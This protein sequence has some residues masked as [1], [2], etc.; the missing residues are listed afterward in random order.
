MNKFYLKVSKYV[1]IIFLVCFAFAVFV[2]QA[3][4]YLPDED[5]VS[6]TIYEKS[7]E[8]IENSTVDTVSALQEEIQ[9]KASV[10]EDEREILRLEQLARKEEEAKRR[11]SERREIREL[12]QVNI[13]EDEILNMNVERLFRQAKEQKESKDYKKAVDSFKQVAEKVEG[14]K[15]AECYEE[16]ATIYGIEKHYGTALSYAQKAY[17][18]EATTQRELLLARLYYKTGNIN[19]ATNRV[20]N[21]LKRDFTQDR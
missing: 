6:N 14:D 13:L 2:M 1:L 11:A 16:I 3:Y 17:N 4:K 10:S 18:I 12:E 9:K 19:S 15:K 8:V 20:N 21:I 7:R 5:N